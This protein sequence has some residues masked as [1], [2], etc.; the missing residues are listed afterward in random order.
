MHSP[1]FENLI[2]SDL[3]PY[4]ILAIFIQVRIGEKPY[5]CLDC[6]ILFFIC[7]AIL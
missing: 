2:I 7:L 5:I 6:N 4:I 3:I 1:L